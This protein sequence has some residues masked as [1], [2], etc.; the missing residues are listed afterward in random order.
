ML[1]FWRLVRR[2]GALEMDHG[3]QTEAEEKPGEGPMN[4]EGLQEGG[5]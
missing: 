3:R 4:P 5:C 2:G 1:K